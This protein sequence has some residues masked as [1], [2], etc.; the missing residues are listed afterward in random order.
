ML[1]YILIKV[2]PFQWLCHK[3]G[4]N[5][6]PLCS[7]S[8]VD[9]RKMWLQTYASL[10][11][12]LP[13]KTTVLHFISWDILGTTFAETNNTKEPSQTQS[14]EKNPCHLVMLL[15]FWLIHPSKYKTQQSGALVDLWQSKDCEF[16]KQSTD[17]FYSFMVP[18]DFF[19]QI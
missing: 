3:T 19:I 5:K 14:T 16:T 9:K 4:C 11:H 10:T 18:I 1:I 12:I 7:K 13:G 8:H 17:S 6:I 15:I 2:E